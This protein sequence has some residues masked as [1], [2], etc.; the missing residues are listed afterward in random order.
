MFLP[1]LSNTTLTPHAVRQLANALGNV[2]MAVVDDMLAAMGQ[3]D[4]TLGLGGHGA[5]DVQTEQ[6]G[7]LRYDQAH[8]TGS[9]VQQNAVASL[10]IVNASHQ[11]R[12]R[13]AA[14]GHGRGGFET[15]GFRQFDQRRGRDQT[16]GAVGTQG[17]EKTGVGDAIAD[18]Y[19]GHP[20]A[21]GLD[22][23]GRFNPP[24]PLGIGIG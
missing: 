4:F 13:Q 8:T 16:F 1:T 24:M 2:F 3:G 10:E 6:L 20:F 19:V 7:P 18:L 21:D 12:G 5:N 17:I 22:H 15:D 14:H 9:G 23:T 11:V